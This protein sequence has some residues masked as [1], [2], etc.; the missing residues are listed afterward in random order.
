MDVCIDEMEI[1]LLADIEI[2]NLYKNRIREGLTT[3]IKHYAE[4]NNEYIIILTYR[5]PLYSLFTLILTRTITFSE[6][7][8]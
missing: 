2:L 1:Q 8:N 6:P 4:A 7:L 3:A 5:I